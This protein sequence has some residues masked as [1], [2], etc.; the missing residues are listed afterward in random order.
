MPRQHISSLQWKYFQ[1]ILEVDAAERI[2]QIA[3][4]KVS[5]PA[6]EHR[7][8]AA[9][10]GRALYV[11][12]KVNLFLRTP[13]DIYAT[14]HN[15]LKAEPVR[16]I[17]SFGKPSPNYFI[18]SLMT[19]ERSDTAQHVFIDDGRQLQQFRVSIDLAPAVKLPAQALSLTHLKVGYLRSLVKYGV[20]VIRKSGPGIDIGNIASQHTNWSGCIATAVI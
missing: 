12:N 6:S 19:D 20:P 18:V 11:K 17:Y 1:I 7:M 13:I 9:L 8:G 16:V 5:G 4:T 15:A 3:T 2:A 10:V 14:P